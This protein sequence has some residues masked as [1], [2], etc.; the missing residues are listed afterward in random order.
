[1]TNQDNKEKTKEEKVLEELRECQ[2]LK[3]EYLNEWKR[4]R[5]DF[6]NYKKEEET[7][8]EEV[9]KNTRKDLILNVLIPL[10]D[11]LDIF[12][13]NFEKESEFQKVIF[14]LKSQIEDFLKKESIFRMKTVG[15]KFDPYF[16]EAVEM[17]EGLEEE[18]GKIKEEILAGYFWE[19]KVLRPAKV[20]VVKF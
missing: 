5:A 19:K 1:M 10:L 15:E 6:I 4:A 11:N 20:K 18:K 13:K 9:R 7:R 14:C 2:R 3:E 8:M 16:H 12:E 17:V